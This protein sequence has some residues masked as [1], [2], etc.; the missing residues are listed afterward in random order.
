MGGVF[1]YIRTPLG[2][3]LMLVVAL[4][5]A[6]IAAAAAISGALTAAAVSAAGFLSIVF[7]L[8]MVKLAD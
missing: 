7:I 4:V 8:A 3:I 1:Q 5:C 6:G 2:A